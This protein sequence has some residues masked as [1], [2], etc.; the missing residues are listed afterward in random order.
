MKTGIVAEGGE[1]IL[2]PRKNGWYN[3]RTNTK[4]VVRGIVMIKMEQIE[5][6][7]KGLPEEAQVLLLDFIQLLRKRYSYSQL[8]IKSVAEF[9]HQKAKQFREWAESHKHKQFPILSDKDISRESIY[10]ERGL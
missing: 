3:R 8:Y 9:P 5:K 2:I 6:D 4:L 7:I 1:Y 10:G